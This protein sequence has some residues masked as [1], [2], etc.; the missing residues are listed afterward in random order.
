MLKDYERKAKKNKEIMTDE[1]YAEWR[2]RRATEI[3]NLLNKQEHLAK[4]MVEADQVATEAIN[5]QMPLVY[6]E[7]FNHGTYQVESVGNV[8]TMYT[9][10]DADTVDR[11]IKEQP[12]LLPKNL[13]LN[14]PKDLRWNQQHITSAIT[15]GIIQGE[16]I[17]KIARR[18]QSV[19]GMDE[20]ASIRNARTATN[21]A[22]NAGRLNAYKR[23]RDMGIDVKKKWLATYDNRTRHSHA[24]IDGEK[25]NLDD[26]FS[27]GCMCPGD[28]NGPPGEIYN[29]RCT[30]IP[31]VNGEDDDSWKDNVLVGDKGYEQWKEEH[32][33][34]L[35]KREGRKKKTAAKSA[36]AED[37]L[38]DAIVESYDYHVGHNNL[39]ASTSAEVGKEFFK[40][41]FTD[42]DPEIK[43]AMSDQLATLCQKYDTTLQQVRPM[44][45][46]EFAAHR[47]AFAS[48]QHNYSVDS[49]LIMYNPVKIKD[50]DRVKEL[51]QKGWMA[52]VDES[53][54]AR[55]CM[56]HEFGH[57][58][59]DMVSPLDEKTNWLGA[60]YKRLT[61][62]RK[63]I[64]SVYDK[65]IND[66]VPLEKAKK[67]AEMDAMLGD[68]SAWDK[69]KKL[70]K[71]LKSKKVSTYS[72]ES[73]DEFMAECFAHHEL[74]GG[75]NE[76]VDAIMA[77]INK[78][79]R[80]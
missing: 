40:V 13:K 71:E 32:R 50:V 67:A 27:N 54:A 72:L 25:V 21:G 12:E 51:I 70:S 7:G 17:D 47:K 11:L 77:I 22:Q 75:D 53:L 62:I 68:D 49:S 79:F 35:E 58:L 20:R 23:G 1:E 63:E 6:G 55:Y 36:N 41:Q 15:Q 16:S 19:V 80:R 66:V 69:A 76:Y 8:N 45:K 9:L 61:A 65:Y 39:N 60:D 59:I 10:Y 37:N 30:L 44:D 43:D 56:T 14:I 74:G 28:P 48:T 73:S 46:M 3:S 64:N 78:H 2:R 5:S 31:V 4:M 57:T 42:M 18:L 38:R 24:V 26:E 33:Q 34:A 29:C 52:D